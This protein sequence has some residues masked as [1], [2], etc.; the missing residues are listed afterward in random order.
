M[1]LFALHG[2]VKRFGGL[3]ATD[4]VDLSVERGEIH[5]LIG[6]NGAGKTTLV[7]QISGTLAP[8]Q[9]R[10]VLDGVELTR[11]AGPPPRARPACR[12]ASRSP[13]SFRKQACATT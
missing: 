5:A 2:L 11:P 8:D 13:A 12:A 3:L 9:G 6:P 7:N 1:S 10:V 4:H